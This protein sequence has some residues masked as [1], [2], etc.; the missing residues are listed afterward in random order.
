[1]H[2]VDEIVRSLVRHSQ[3]AGCV[4]DGQSDKAECQI[5]PDKETPLWVPDWLPIYY[6]AA[7]EY[8]ESESYY[9]SYNGQIIAHQSKDW[10]GV[11]GT[12]IALYGN[13]DYIRFIR[14][15][16]FLPIS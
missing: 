12:V 9:V 6:W 1:M 2:T 16:Y 8:S 15:I 13:R 11:Q 3:N 14:R 7:D 4:W 5:I 10:G